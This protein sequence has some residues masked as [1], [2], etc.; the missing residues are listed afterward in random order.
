M[1]ISRR[2]FL[3]GFA[4]IL[5]A[6]AIV[7]ASSLMPVKV[8]DDD[9]LLALRRDENGLIPA[10]DLIT[11]YRQ[12]FIAQ[13]EGNY[14]FLRERVVSEVIVHCEDVCFDVA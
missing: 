4:G 3:T 7:R 2:G 11:R 10:H 8:I 9:V 1:T 6:P 13:F 12:E 14:S 5:A